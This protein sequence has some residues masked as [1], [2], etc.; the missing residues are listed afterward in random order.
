MSTA[1]QQTERLELVETHNL[2]LSIKRLRSG[3]GGH[4][5]SRWKRALLH[6][7]LMEGPWEHELR[8]KLRAAL[9]IP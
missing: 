7:I 1:R 4:D 2:A 3:N 8:S 9:E 5:E 6:A